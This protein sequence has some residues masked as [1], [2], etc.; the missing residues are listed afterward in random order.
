MRPAC[1][2]VAPVVP[3]LQHD[4]VTD[5]CGT[6]TGEEEDAVPLLIIGRNAPD[7]KIQRLASRHGMD[8]LALRNFAR[9]R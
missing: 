3:A 2:P 5:R 4:G 6:W 1:S 8:A 9:S 7:D